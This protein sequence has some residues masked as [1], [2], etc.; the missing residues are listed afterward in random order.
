VRWALNRLAL[1]ITSMVALA[2]LVPL[3]VATRQIAHDRAISDARQQATALV[4]VLGVDADP[5]LL[6]NAVASTTAGGEGR[7]AVHLPAVAPIGA[8]HLSD[9]QVAAA[10]RDRRPVLATVAGGV[11]YLQPTVLTDGRTVIV[12]VFV[13]SGELRRGVWPAWLAL[14]GLAIVLVA[15]STLMADRLGARL[16]RSTRSL[17]ASA[18][19]LGG[20]ELSVRVPPDGPRELRDAARAFNTMADDLRRLMDRERELAA[21]LSHRL[22][23]PLTALRLDAEAMPAGPIGE[24][25]RQ[26]CDL[27]D[28]ELDAIIRGP[29]RGGATRTDLVDVLADRLAFWSVLAEDQERPWEVVGGDEPVMVS[30]PRSELILVVDAMLGNVFAHTPEGVAFRVSVSPSELLVDDAGPGILDPA[31]AVRRGVSGA[32]STGL[33]LDIVRKAADA[34]SGRLV[35]ARGPLGGA[36]VGIFF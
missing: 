36:R 34:V 29:S 12:E 10:A 2:F 24:R 7:L 21:D 1:A 22:R 8:T 5:T 23:T 26:A 27:L 16:V 17:A 3:A 6:T 35:V 15:G 13:P 31:A 33:G 19:R 9:V 18:R 25:M 30:L 11:A 14:G 32:G 28:S 4:T 20:G